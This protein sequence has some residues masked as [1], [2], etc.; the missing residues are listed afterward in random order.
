M[1]HVSYSP[2]FFEPPQ[3]WQDRS[4]AAFFGQ[5]SP[6]EAIA[7]NIVVTR[8]PRVDGDNLR[9]HVQRQ[10]VLLA[11]ALGGFEVLE[12]EEIVVGGRRAFRTRCTW[13]AENAMVEQAIVHLEPDA[14]DATVT[15][16]TCTSSAASAASVLPVFQ[17]LVG[18]FQLAGERPKSTQRQVLAPVR[19]GTR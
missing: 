2:Y 4:V 1:P 16:L 14:D 12:S 6:G 8:E 9:T 19:W 7:P 11:S 5:A 10:V 18:T 3:G 15:V 13:N 17:R